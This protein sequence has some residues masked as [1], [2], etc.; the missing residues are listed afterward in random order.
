MKLQLY[1]SPEAWRD[2]DDIASYIQTHSPGSAV[3]FFDTCWATFEKLCEN[4]QIGPV[5]EDVDPQ[6]EGL[7]KWALHR[8]LNYL[9]YYRVRE[10]RIEIVHVY[11]GAQ[12]PGRFFQSPQ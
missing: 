10:D 3:R 11:H 9:I 7:R 5:V 6:W 1:V 12:D 4:P 8:F 2:V